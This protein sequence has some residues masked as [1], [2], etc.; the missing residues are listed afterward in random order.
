M[1]AGYRLGGGA[2][3]CWLL[4]SI[5]REWTLDERDDG[6]LCGALV[7]HASGRALVFTELLSPRQQLDLAEC[8]DDR[9]LEKH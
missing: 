2:A 8:Q 3:G 7:R 6:N 5:V 4:P 1:G 9:L